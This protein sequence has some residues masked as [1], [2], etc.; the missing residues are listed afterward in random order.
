MNIRIMSLIYSQNEI[1]VY[2]RKYVIVGTLSTLH[3]KAT[4]G[5]IALG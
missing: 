2:Y 4:V 1:V 5:Q 3:K